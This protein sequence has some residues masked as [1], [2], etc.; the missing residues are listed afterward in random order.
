MNSEVEKEP[1]GFEILGEDDGY[2]LPKFDGI[3]VLTDHKE[4][5]ESGET[6][7]LTD[8]VPGSMD[9]KNQT[10]VASDQI[11]PSTNRATC[12][13]TNSPTKKR[14]DSGARF[15]EMDFEA[16]RDFTNTKR[17]TL[18]ESVRLCPVFVLD[19]ACGAKADS[20]LV[21]CSIENISR[22]VRGSAIS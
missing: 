5:T 14:S 1:S 15:V 8:I 22:P 2:A 12:G 13:V 17:S 7:P 9:N 18:K 19:I 21:S 11:E 6:A 3:E 4:S 16:S 20:R 10:S